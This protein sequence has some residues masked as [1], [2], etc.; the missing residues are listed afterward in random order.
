MM[1]YVDFVVIFSTYQLNVA[2]ILR[3]VINVIHNAVNITI[4]FIQDWEQL[5]FYFENNHKNQNSPNCIQTKCISAS[6]S[7]WC[8]VNQ[9][10]CAWILQWYLQQKCLSTMQPHCHFHRF[11]R[12]LLSQHRI[13]EIKNTETFCTTIIVQRISLK[14]PESYQIR[15]VHKTLYPEENNDL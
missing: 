11:E 13:A 15:L 9:W 12:V 8:F 5:I 6:L 4:D 3:N 7:S 14:I 1:F 10:L 2:C